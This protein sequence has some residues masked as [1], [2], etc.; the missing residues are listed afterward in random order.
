MKRSPAQSPRRSDERR[1]PSARSS[2]DPVADAE[3]ALAE[4]EPR[5]GADN[6]DPVAEAEEA[7]SGAGAGAGAGSSSSAV[8]AAG[9]VTSYAGL[10]TANK[11]SADEC[12]V[13]SVLMVQKLSSA[14]KKGL[15]KATLVYSFLDG[16]EHALPSS[17]VD[18]KAG[19][20][21]F[22]DADRT[23]PFPD[24]HPNTPLL[25][26]AVAPGANEDAAK[27]VFR[28]KAS[29]SDTLLGTAEYSL[30][31]I[32]EKGDSTS[33]LTLPLQSPS[34]SAVPIGKLVCGISASSVLLRMLSGVSS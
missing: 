31:D 23:F 27:I 19:T 3:A 33:H 11:L 18:A 28:L 21:S 1:S 24:G 7:L 15:K 20:V 4:D 13:V 26:A 5:K 16:T 29:G 32:L 6:A 8:A 22:K 17:K 2:D 12:V 14:V 10:P 30:A 25:A 9:T 34:G